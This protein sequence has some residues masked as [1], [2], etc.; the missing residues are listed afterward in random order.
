V[1][2]HKHAK[3]SAV[4]KTKLSSSNVAEI[5]ARTAEQAQSIQQMVRL[6]ESKPGELTFSVRNRVLAGV[7][8]FMTFDVAMTSDQEGGMSTVRTHI[9]SYRQGRQTILFI[10]I[11]PAQMHGWASYKRFMYGLANEIRTQDPT[12]TATVSEV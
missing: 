4:I 7:V 1:K 12:A 6:E 2:P 5:A 10:P 3:A 8:E 11:A 9:A